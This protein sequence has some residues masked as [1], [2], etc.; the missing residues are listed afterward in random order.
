MCPG[1]HRVVVRRRL[2]LEL[3]VFK[4]Q[5]DEKARSSRP[6]S[7]QRQCRGRDGRDRRDRHSSRGRDEHSG[8]GRYSGLER[9]SGHY[10][11]RRATIRAQESTAQRVTYREALFRGRKPDAAAP[12]PE[13]RPHQ[14][15]SPHV[16][17][18]QGAVQQRAEERDAM[19][20]ATRSDVVGR[21]MCAVCRQEDAMFHQLGPHRPATGGRRLRSA[22]EVDGGHPDAPRNGRAAS[23]LARP[24]AMPRVPPRRCALSG[25]DDP[26][27]GRV[28]QVL[29]T[30]P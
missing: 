20:L 6:S 18:L 30:R 5:G 13:A 16:R 21:A 10:P 28:Q 25:V 4:L 1:R 14:V 9:Y 7:C 23:E 22:Q 29:P 8:R 19:Q 17:W 2:H 12:E 27:D 26:Y 24:Q 11:G 3:C 15:V